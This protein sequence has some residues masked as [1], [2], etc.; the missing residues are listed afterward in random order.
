M[1]SG[2][3]HESAFSGIIPNGPCFLLIKYSNGGCPGFQP[4]SLLI[5]SAV[6]LFEPYLLYLFNCHFIL[7]RVINEVNKKRGEVSFAAVFM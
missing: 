1:M 7:A 2:K 3:P 5:Y 6:M 4:G